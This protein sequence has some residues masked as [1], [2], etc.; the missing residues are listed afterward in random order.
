[1][2]NVSGAESTIPAILVSTSNDFS[3]SDNLVSTSN[4][5][6]YSDNLVST[7]NDF[8][9]SDNLASTSADVSYTDKSILFVSKSNNNL[10]VD[11]A[12]PTYTES[13]SFTFVIE[14]SICT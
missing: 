10:V 1:M 3:Y 7:S 12:I 13:T 8:S 4:D 14:P 5:F 9:Y 11:I 6:S 2:F